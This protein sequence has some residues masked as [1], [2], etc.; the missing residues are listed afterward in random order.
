VGR[1]RRGGPLEVLDFETKLKAASGAGVTDSP[2]G[3]LAPKARAR[4]DTRAYVG[5]RDP[6]NT[7]ISLSNS[8]AHSQQHDSET[9]AARPAVT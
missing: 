2:A 3:G 8:E 1:W 7:A 4:C 5:G 6:Q 9:A